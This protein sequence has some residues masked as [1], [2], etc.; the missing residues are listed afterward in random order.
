MCTYVEII[1]IYRHCNE[2]PKHQEATKDYIRCNSIPA[3]YNYCPDPSQVGLQYSAQ[4]QFQDLALS[5]RGGPYR[6]FLIRPISGDN[7]QQL[8]DYV[9][10]AIASFSRR[11]SVGYARARVLRVNRSESSKPRR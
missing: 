6:H 1:K 5:V 7:H 4:Y 10:I 9:A 3:N 11:A 8:D 2:G